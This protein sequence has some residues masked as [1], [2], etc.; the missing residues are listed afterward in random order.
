MI[1]QLI[2]KLS[3]PISFITCLLV[4]QWLNN[5]FKWETQAW[6]LKNQGQEM[7][8]TGPDGEVEC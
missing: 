8:V 3:Y 6:L 5:G 4:Y 1:M 7:G 2:H